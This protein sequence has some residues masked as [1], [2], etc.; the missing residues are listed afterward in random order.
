MDEACQDLVYPLEYR[1]EPDGCE[2]QDENG[3]FFEK[4]IMKILASAEGEGTV[5]FV[6]LNPASDAVENL[7]A[8][9]RRAD[10]DGQPV[11]VASGLYTAE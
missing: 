3:F 1:S 10:M 9:V 2:T 7:T 11:V 4:E 8:Y 6:W 5:S